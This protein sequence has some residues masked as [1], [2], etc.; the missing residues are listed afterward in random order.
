MSFENWKQP[1]LNNRICF[2]IIQLFRTPKTKGPVEYDSESDDDE[3]DEEPNEKKAEE[4]E[5]FGNKP[6][7]KDGFIPA[8]KAISQLTKSMQNLNESEDKK[9]ESDKKEEWVKVSLKIM[10]FS[11]FKN[12]NENFYFKRIIKR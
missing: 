6:Y 4:L 2:I 5:T 9:T 7:Y 1:F 10:I 8:I 3:N 12:F 11:V